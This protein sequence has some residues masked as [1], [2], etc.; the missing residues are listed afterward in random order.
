MYA[1][2]TIPEI[3]L[4]Y[5]KGTIQT[6]KIT[7]SSQTADI[8]RQMYDADTLEYCE[9]FIIILLNRANKTLGWIKISQGG[10]TGTVA[11]PR[12]I[13]AA[14]LKAGATA[15]ILSHNHPSGNLTPS[16]AD[17]EMTKKI[18]AGGLLL[19]INVL[20]HIIVTDE[21]FYSFADEGIL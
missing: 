13:F 15:V 7:S 4:K 2:Q 18:K 19:D 14:A 1:N 10:L 20:D 12:M 9:S 8:L 17:E 6:V 21:G 16:R 3:T 5:K 11:D